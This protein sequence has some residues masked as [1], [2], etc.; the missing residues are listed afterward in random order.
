MDD[1]KDGVFRPIIGYHV[2]DD[3]HWVAQ[4]ACGHNQHVRHLPPLVRR[5]WVQTA[6]GRDQ[7]I[8]FELCCRKCVEGAPADERPAGT[9]G[10][11]P[12]NG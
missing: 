4:L 2:D 10:T 8:G 6:E 3:Q 5:E 9:V 1:K 12:G 7:M 11:R